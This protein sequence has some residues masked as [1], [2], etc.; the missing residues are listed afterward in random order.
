M[1]ACYQAKKDV[2]MM[3][4]LIQLIEAGQ[5]V[6]DVNRHLNG[7][8]PK[9]PKTWTPL[10]ML[11]DGRCENRDAERIRPWIVKLLLLALADAMDCY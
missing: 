4:V 2:H 6:A 5:S 1:W 11:C 10:H 7:S 9:A 3:S 8:Q